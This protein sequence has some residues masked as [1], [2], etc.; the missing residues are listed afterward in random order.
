M[1][2]C[3]SEKRAYIKTL[4]ESLNANPKSQD[5]RKESLFTIKYKKANFALRGEQRSA[6]L[7]AFSKAS[8]TVEAAVVLPVFLMFFTALFSLFSIMSVQIRMQG[9]LNEVAGEIAAYYY[10]AD[11]LT[12]E[13]NAEK[14]SVIQNVGIDAAELLMSEALVRR[15]VTE[16]MQAIAE[17]PMLMNGLEGLQFIGSG[18]READQTVEVCVTYGVLIPF[19]PEKVGHLTLSQSAVR[20]AWNGKSVD[21]GITEKIVYITES[22]TVYHTSLS[23][24]H[25]KL[26]IEAVRAA[27]VE[28]RRN[29]DGA[30]Y[31]ECELCDDRPHGTEVYITASGNRYHYDANCSGLKR[32]VTSVPIS[33]VGD[34]KL[35]SRCKT[36]EKG[37]S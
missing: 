22:G 1:L 32:T 36:R 28:H 34:K 20:R 27:V 15:K 31:Y 10:A 7:S 8:L 29:Q 5:D 4:H 18:F 2:L 16:E 9:V 21:E 37:G 3:E 23:C 30:K 12:G 17:H 11:K 14:R 33:Q 19:V 35:C 6:F 13:N 26:S 25:L 24:T